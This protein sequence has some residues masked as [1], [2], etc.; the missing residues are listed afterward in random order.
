MKER[1]I[2]PK[3]QGPVLPH[4]GDEAIGSE[5]MSGE[6]GELPPGRLPWTNLQ[7]A[8]RDSFDETIGTPEN[9]W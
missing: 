5:A 3:L 6:L 1:R 8:R 7:K 4:G 2:Q 9:D